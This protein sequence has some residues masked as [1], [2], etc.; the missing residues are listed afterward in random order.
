MVAQFTASFSSHS[1]KS[2]ETCYAWVES[3][4]FMEAG[5]RDFVWGTIR[6]VNRGDGRESLGCSTV[7]AGGFFRTE[8]TSGWA[9][10]GIN[11]LACRAGFY[12][13]AGIDGRHD[14]A[15]GR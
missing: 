2:Q 3:P 9:N 1:G 6:L 12:T 7:F 14:A 8:H 5:E 13:R 15:E 4:L 11:H 10:C